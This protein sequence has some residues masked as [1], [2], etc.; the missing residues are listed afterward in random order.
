MKREKETHYFVAI[1]RGTLIKEY[2]L[3]GGA[4]GRVELEL[5]LKGLRGLVQF[6]SKVLVDRRPE[7]E[8]LGEGVCERRRSIKSK[9]RRPHE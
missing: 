4:D 9:V 3:E 1:H 6:S 2:R 8:D 7:R 5:D